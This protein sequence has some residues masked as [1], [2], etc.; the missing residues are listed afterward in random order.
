MGGEREVTV[1]TP[2]KVTKGSVDLLSGEQKIRIHE[3]GGKVHFHVDAENL[4]VEIPVAEWFKAWQFLSKPSE[5]EHQW[6]YADPEHGT[7]LS[8]TTSCKN[9]PLET[10]ISIVKM[11]FGPTYSALQKFTM[12]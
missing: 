5:T 11:D 1:K 8:T 12:G 6:M 3:S 4:K 7:V 9:Q 2:A 10:E